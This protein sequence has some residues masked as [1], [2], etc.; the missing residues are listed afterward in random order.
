MKLPFWSNK[1]KPPAPPIE[2]L[3]S[4]VRYALQ[5]RNAQ[6]GKEEIATAVNSPFFREIGFYFLSKALDKNPTAQKNFIEEMANS[7]LENGDYRELHQI[8]AKYLD[9]IPEG[10]SIAG[11]KAGQFSQQGDAIRTGFDRINEKVI[12]SNRL[13]ILSLYASLLGLQSF[14]KTHGARKIILFDHKK[15]GPNIGYL[16]VNSDDKIAVQVLTLELLQASIS[17]AALSI[18]DDHRRTGETQSQIADKVKTL[19]GPDV[20]I[21]FD[22]VSTYNGNSV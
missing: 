20:D 18:I 16:L 6:M 5:Y 2:V 13:P 14:I 8:G 4:D 3:S 9:Q 7:L 1:E 21:I 12:T 19:C 22:Q 11:D 15:K 17:Q 10:E